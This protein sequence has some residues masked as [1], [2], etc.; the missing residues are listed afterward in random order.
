MRKP[1]S[2]PRRDKFTEFQ[3][4]HLKPEAKPYLVW[5][6]FQRG[7]VVRVEVSG[8]KSFKA[9]Y[10]LGGRKRDYHIGNAAAISLATARKLARGIMDQVA[11]KK[12][13]QAI[14]RSARS[15]GT[16]DDIADRYLEYSKK[17]NKSWSQADALVRRHLRPKWGKLPAADVSRSDVKA[18][19]SR[20]EA[21][22]L[23]NQVL[24]SASAIFA[25]GIREELV[26]VNPC[27]GIERNK[28]TSRERIL[29]DS[30]I[31]LFWPLMSTTL[32]LILLTGQRPGE[33]SAMRWEHIENNWWTL[34]GSPA[35]GWRGTKNGQTHTVWLSVPV[36]SLMEE[37]QEDADGP[38]FPRL[39]SL[40]AEM[41]TICKQL[42]VNRKVTPHDLRRTFSSKVTGLAFGRDAMDRVTNHRKG[43]IT[44][45]YDRHHYSEENKKIM[46]TVA[47]HILALVG[48]TPKG[49]VV[50]LVR[51]N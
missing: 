37:L 33:V 42:G 14:K 6:T 45:V 43:G 13:P 2:A 21:P 49:N 27:H 23:A 46:E 3:I 12:D 7:L 4:N 30:E 1:R 51:S 40:D 44:S 9:I 19:M 48:G 29:S 38:V 41:R 26:K 47:A 50:P 24:A 34:P 32:K 39:G 18:M 16:F 35:E 22:V 25:W 20:I 28:T 11:E 36:Q 8:H 17:R 10:K 15:T 31:P 5:D